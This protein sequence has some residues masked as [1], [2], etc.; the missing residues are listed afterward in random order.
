[1]NFKDDVWA[2]PLHDELRGVEVMRLTLAAVLLTHPL[3]ALLVHE[4]VARLEAQLAANHAPVALAVP[5]FVVLALSAAAL[6]TRRFALI[7]AV[8]AATVV[9][10]GTV[11]LNL[12]R[13]FVLGGEVLEGELGAEYGVLLV[14]MLAGVAWTWRS[15]KLEDAQRAAKVGLRV[16]VIGSALSLA[17]HGYGAFIRHDVEGM[18]A[19]GEA[20]SAAGWPFG[21]A[22]VWSVKV[23][24]QLGV[25]ARVAGRLVIPACVGH[26]A[27]LLTGMVVSQELAWFTIGGGEG[28]IEFPV[29]LCAGAIAH[30][31][32]VWPRGMWPRR[33]RSVA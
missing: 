30:L 31:L 32:S 29:V 19:W 21:V 20:M 14:V 28:G 7:G 12:P 27:V 22:L 23:V 2:P 26:L 24:E 10:L 25:W 9:G 5:S 16:V 15:P 6:F 17:P 1:M 18:R 13:W 3:H 11:L 4:D 33:P 8:G